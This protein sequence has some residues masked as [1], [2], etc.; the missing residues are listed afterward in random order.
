M[1]QLSISRRTSQTMNKNAIY[2]PE[3]MVTF[4]LKLLKIVYFNL[5]WVL[6]PYQKQ[7]TNKKM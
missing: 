3:Y 6:N 2:S 1:S 7:K 5:K 4:I